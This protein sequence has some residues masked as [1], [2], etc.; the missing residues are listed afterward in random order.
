MK[1]TIYKTTN[2]INNKIYIGKHQTTNINDDYFGSGKLLKQAVKKYGKNNF[3]KE[4]IHVYDTEEEMNQKE[5]E[6]VTESFIKRKDTYNLCVGGNG[7]N[8]GFSYINKNFWTKEKR[9]EHNTKAWAI[10][11]QKVSKN[12]LKEY[13][14]KGA[15]KR[16]SLYGNPNTDGS[17]FR[18]KKHS[19]KT[20]EK[21][22]HAH[23][24]KHIGNKNS[25]Y[26][27]IWITNGIENKKNHKNS[28]IPD[29]WMHGRIMK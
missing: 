29:G 25:Q 24:G 9:L 19:E 17:S 21:M 16:N 13:A 26:G 28:A 23:N 8:D 18:G 14:T 27:T 12:Q 11:R 7:G 10:G 3:T 5:K 22:R 2:K 15:R 20:K 6:L 1:Y 4:I